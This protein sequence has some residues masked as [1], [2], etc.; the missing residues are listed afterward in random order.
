MS[1][2]EQLQREAWSVRG[3]IKKT[4]EKLIAKFYR[5]F[6]KPNA[7]DEYP[8]PRAQEKAHIAGRVAKLL[9]DGSPFHFWSPGSKCKAL[10]PSEHRC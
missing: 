10:T 6:P 9:K 1:Y 2:M 5:I 4:V 3:K 8:N 7:Y